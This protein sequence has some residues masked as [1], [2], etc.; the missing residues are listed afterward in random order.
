MADGQP[1]LKD[2]LPGCWAHAFSLDGRSLAVGQ[3]DW[4][5][6][7][8]LSTGLEL[9]RWRLPAPAHTMAFHPAVAAKMARVAY[10]VITTGIDFRRFPEAAKPGGRIPSPAAV[11][12]HATS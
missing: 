6:C 10:A 2:Q 4:A 12:A 1:V 11:E 3:Q 7:F 8:D 5:I 9:R